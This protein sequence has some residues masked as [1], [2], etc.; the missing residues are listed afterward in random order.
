MFKKATKKQSLLRL[1]IY[2]PSGSG[3]TYSSMSIA[4]G[5]LE[6]KVAVI[7]SERGSASK[8]AGKFNFDV[9]ELRDHSTESY[10]NAIRQAVGI[11][12]VLI[13]DSL[14]HAWT[15]L[16]D[17]SDKVARD[18]FGGNTWAAWSKLTPKHNRLIDE[19]CR[20]PGHIIVT[21]RSRNVWEHISTPKGDKPVKNGYMPDQRD[22]C[23]YEFDMVMRMDVGHKATIEKDRTGVF[24]SDVIQN[25]DKKFGKKLKK[26]L[27]E[28]EPND[29]ISEENIKKLQEEAKNN[30]SEAKKMLQEKG[31][32]KTADVTNND[33][34]DLLNKFKTINSKEQ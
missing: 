6:K 21:M 5:L 22:S 33:F 34:E 3:K 16:K 30:I 11:Y 15:F 24:Q 28:G 27:F 20:F 23:V 32:E 19:I 2:G 31:Y 9:A 10:I 12:D 25:P 7:D 14:T 4:T 13:I 26:W 8:Y 1:S 17:N 18:S 29:L